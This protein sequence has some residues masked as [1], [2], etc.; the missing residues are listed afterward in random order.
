MFYLFIFKHDVFLL[1]TFSNYTIANAAMNAIKE[2]NPNQQIWIEPVVCRDNLEYT[3]NK[4]EENW[5]K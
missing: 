2:I 3:I 1:D 4:Y 5:K